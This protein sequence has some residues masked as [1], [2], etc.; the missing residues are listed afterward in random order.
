MAGKGT[1]ILVLGGIAALAVMPKKKRR[2]AV[3]KKEAGIA[4][5][6]VIDRTSPPTASDPNSLAY[7]WRVREKP[8]IG[9]VYVAEIGRPP[10]RTPDVVKTWK[11]IGEADNAA[12]AR[13]MA[14]SAIGQIPGYE[15]ELEIADAGQEGDLEWRV[16]VDAERGYVGQYRLTGGQWMAALEGPSYDEGFKQR[17]L[18]I[19]RKSG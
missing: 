2:K 12:D 8:A 13:D 6:G 16:Y 7:H 3:A 17:L 4:S 18:E 14:I 10:M 11:V 15:P 5:S 19:A 9:I 1:A